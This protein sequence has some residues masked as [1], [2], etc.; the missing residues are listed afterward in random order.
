MGYLIALALI[1]KLSGEHQLEFS[2]TIV[3]AMKLE[4]LSGMDDLSQEQNT[5]EV[6]SPK[7]CPWFYID[8]IA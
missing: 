6:S 4:Q 3:N 2:H 8:N 7:N 5:I 1:K